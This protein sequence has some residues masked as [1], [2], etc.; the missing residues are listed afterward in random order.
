MT[1][2]SAPRTPDGRRHPRE[3]VMRRGVL[4]HAPT[5]RSFSCMIVDISVGGAQLH[6]VGTNLPKSDLTLVDVRADATYDVEV[7][8]A[9]WQVLGV[10]FKATKP[11]SAF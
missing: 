1:A 9:R 6:L 4:V 5:G 11:M 3:L 2:A 8:W 10:R 7:I